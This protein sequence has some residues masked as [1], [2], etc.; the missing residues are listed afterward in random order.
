[1]MGLGI[2]FGTSNTSSAAGTLFSST[3]NAGTTGL[4]STPSTSTS[5]GAGGFG[6]AKRKQ[7]LFL[8]Q[9]WFAL[10]PCV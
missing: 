1:M 10:T 9:I 2:G 6:A 4:F 7:F 5:F 3:S 8:I